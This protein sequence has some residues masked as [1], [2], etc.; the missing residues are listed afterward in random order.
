MHRTIQ[1]ITIA[2]IL[3]LP[4]DSNAIVSSQCNENLPITKQALYGSWKYSLGQDVG[5]STFNPDMTFTG[6]L[7]NNGINTR[8]YNGTWSFKN[9]AID[10]LYTFSSSD[11]IKAGTKDH[12]E[13]LEIGCDQI[14]IKS[15][16]GQTGV[17]QRNDGI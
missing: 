10:Y 1:T 2:F 15:M 8:Q 14:K 7:E 11:H 16:M 3:S 12:D 13:V 4:M 5:Y 17:F 6:H 9:N